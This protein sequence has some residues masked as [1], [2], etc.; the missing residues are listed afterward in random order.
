MM[1]VP[2]GAGQSMAIDPAVWTAIG[3]KYDGYLIQY[4]RCLLNKYCSPFDVPPCE[5]PAPQV[6]EKREIGGV[7]WTASTVPMQ[8]LYMPIKGC[9]SPNSTA[10]QRSHSSS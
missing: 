2:L 6:L 8:Q 9:T 7:T 3:K 10:P 1:H 4:K 5:P